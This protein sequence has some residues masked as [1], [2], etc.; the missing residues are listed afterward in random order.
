MPRLASFTSGFPLG[1]ASAHRMGS[2]ILTQSLSTSR[3]PQGGLEFTKN[4]SKV[5]QK[6]IKLDRL[7]V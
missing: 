3:R 2:G 6:W 5:P 7:Q 1:T 4:P